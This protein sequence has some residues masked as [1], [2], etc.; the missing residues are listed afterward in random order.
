M[1][2]FT[3]M[4]TQQSQNYKTGIIN[5]MRYR[6]LYITCPSLSNYTTLAPTGNSNVIKK[7]P[8]TAGYGDI[9]YCN[10]LAIHDYIDVSRLLTKTLEFKIC[11]S[12]GKVI[13]LRGVPV[14]CSLIFMP[15]NMGYRIFKK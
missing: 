13:N 14:S 6:N 11:D 12:F 7:V 10:L 15:N 4:E 8:V 9:I 1:K 5:L 3:S 2:F